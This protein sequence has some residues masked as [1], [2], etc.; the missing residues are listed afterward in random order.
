MENGW[1]AQTGTCSSLEDT[2]IAEIFKT[3]TK[4]NA[5]MI[6]SGWKNTNRENQNI[7]WLH[8]SVKE[9]LGSKQYNSLQAEGKLKILEKELNKGKTIY[10]I[11]ASL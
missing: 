7:Y 2:G 1:T 5:Q 8:L 3:I 6:S 4:F 10:Q 11:L 9:E